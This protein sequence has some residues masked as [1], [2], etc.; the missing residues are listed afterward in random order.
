MSHRHVSAATRE[1]A[2]DSYDDP[3]KYPG[4]TP[5][6]NGAIEMRKAIIRTTLAL[7][8][9]AGVGVLQSGGAQA[10]PEEIACHHE[11][12]LG[13]DLCA[14]ANDDDQ[15]LLLLLDSDSLEAA[16]G[17]FDGGDTAITQVDALVSPLGQTITGMRLLH[18]NNDDGDRLLSMAAGVVEPGGDNATVVS[19]EIENLHDGP[20]SGEIKLTRQE[21]D[22]DDESVSIYWENG[23]CE[24]RMDDEAVAPCIVQ[25]VPQLPYIPYVWLP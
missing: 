8:M 1:R 12:I 4:A 7:A 5:F 21:P 16:V 18:A 20:D 3:I 2:H 23:S 24:I 19:T 22:T 10:L 13:I 14:L 9:I 11:Y 17:Q 15:S 6:T 25:V